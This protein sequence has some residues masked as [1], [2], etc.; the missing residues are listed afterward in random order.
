MHRPCGCGKFGTVTPDQLADALNQAQQR[1]NAAREAMVRAEMRAERARAEVT[2][3]Q[4]AVSAHGHVVG[5]AAAWD[6][7][8]LQLE[9]GP[10]ELPEALAQARRGLA[11]SHGEHEQAERTLQ[12][13]EQHAQ[14][15]RKAA[16]A[17]GAELRSV[18][19]AVTAEGTGRD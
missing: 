13:L 4:A 10:V 8:R 3:A 14:Q 15:L 2:R 18:T 11:A 16:T 5:R 7:E 17:A 9:L 6:Q 1:F 12:L 19:I